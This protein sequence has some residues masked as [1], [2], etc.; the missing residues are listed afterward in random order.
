MENARRPTAPSPRSRSWRL[1]PSSAAWSCSIR[2]CPPIEAIGDHRASEPCRRVSGAAGFTDAHGL[3]RHAGAHRGA[4]GARG[5]PMQ[6]W[7]NGGSRR[8]P[9]QT[10]HRANARAEAQLGAAGAAA[11]DQP[12]DRRAPGPRQHLPGGGAQRRGS[13]AGRFCLLL[14]LST[15]PTTCLTSPRRAEERAAGARAGHAGTRARRHRRQRPV[16]LHERASSSTSRTSRRIDFPFPQRLARGGLRSF[17]A[18]PLQVES[19]VF[20]ALIVARTAPRASAAAN[21]N[22]CAS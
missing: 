22:S 11:S 10:L 19:Q 4:G 17:V 7:E 14:P 15:P 5:T 8:A 21:A 1:P 20:G 13:A 18:A 2:A 6:T 9:G 12:R 3:A 16:A